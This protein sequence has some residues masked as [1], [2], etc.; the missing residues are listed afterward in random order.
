MILLDEFNYTNIVHTASAHFGTHRKKPLS[1]KHIHTN[2]RPNK[3]KIKQSSLMERNG[4]DTSIQPYTRQH[5]IA[6]YFAHH[7]IQR[8]D[9]FFLFFMFVLSRSPFISY[10]LYIHC[11]GST[12]NIKP[13]TRTIE[14]FEHGLC[15][16]WNRI[17]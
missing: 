4:K 14:T 11:T 10:C 1:Y 12:F 9:S 2:N 16:K 5:F 15:E 13:N 17:R 7:S 8:F 3:T 6:I